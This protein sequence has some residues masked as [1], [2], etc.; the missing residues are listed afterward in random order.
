MTDKIRMLLASH[1]PGYEVWSVM[2]LGEGL[3]N[4]AHEVNGELMVRTSKE[5]DPALR[6]GTPRKTTGESRSACPPKPVV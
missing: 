2:A 1:L 4:A 5:A 6:A 3:D